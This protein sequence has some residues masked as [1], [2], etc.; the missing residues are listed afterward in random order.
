M[1]NHIEV[2]HIFPGAATVSVMTGSAADSMIP[3]KVDG[4][5]G[6]AIVFALLK[7]TVISAAPKAGKKNQKDE[8]QQE[9]AV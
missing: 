4:V 1:A 5:T 3:V 8:R 2:S 6:F 9:V 7:L